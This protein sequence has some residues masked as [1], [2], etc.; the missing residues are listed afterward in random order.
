M[1]SETEAWLRQQSLTE[2]S[3]PVIAL[4]ADETGYRAIEDLQVQIWG[5]E[6]RALVPAHVLH[7]ASTCGGILLG[8]HVEGTLV[9]FA[10]GFL[11]RK[12]AR[13][14]HV[15][16]MVGIHPDYQGRGIGAALKWGQRQRALEQRLDL[17]TWTFD[18]LEVRNAYFNL[19]KLGAFTRK[20]YVDYYGDLGDILNR[21]LPTDRLMVEWEL[22]NPLHRKVVPDSTARPILENHDGIPVLS[23][24]PSHLGHPLSIVMPDDIQQLKREDPD[25]AL[26]WRMAMRETLLWAFTRDYVVRDIVKGAYIAT[27]DRNDSSAGKGDGAAKTGQ[28]SKLNAPRLSVCR[29]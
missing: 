6:S 13:L 21:G 29:I 15:S 19:H 22:R 18:P 7:I 10:L 2:R 16:H 25:L 5:F 28:G 3:E 17:M 14:C 4:V 24:D 8:A 9:G 1:K 26:E 27:P 11:G 23:L 12:D 20:Y